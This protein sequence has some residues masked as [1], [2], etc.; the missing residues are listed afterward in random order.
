MMRRDGC[1]GQLQ[2]QNAQAA[3][4]LGFICGSLPVPTINPSSTPFSSTEA[5]LV[6]AI[7]LLSQRCAD[8]HALLRALIMIK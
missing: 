7:N 1:V 4:P 2:V 6:P 8:R 5:A 3:V